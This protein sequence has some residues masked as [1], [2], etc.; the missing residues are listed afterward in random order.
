[1]M[2]SRYGR[3]PQRGFSA[4]L[5]FFFFFGCNVVHPLSPFLNRYNEWSTFFSHFSEVTQGSVQ[6][7]SS[8]QYQ[9]QR[10][11]VPQ[12]HERHSLSYPLVI[13]SNIRSNDSTEFEC[14]IFVLCFC[15]ILILSF[16]AFTFLRPQIGQYK[17]NGVPTSRTSVSE[18]KDLPS[19]ISGIRFVFHPVFLGRNWLAL[20][21]YVNPVMIHS[22]HPLPTDIAVTLSKYTLNLL[23]SIP[24]VVYDMWFE[25]NIQALSM[26]RSAQGPTGSLPKCI[27]LFF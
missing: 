18:R 5:L 7:H 13:D 20:I 12:Q 25:S 14:V 26:E 10:Q 16:L 21:F 2:P 11:R 4:S 19:G 6:D 24:D 27:I 1:M 8:G 23:S 22:G 3:M 9:H 15:W 17:D